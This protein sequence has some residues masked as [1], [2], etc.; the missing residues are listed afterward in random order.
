MEIKESHSRSQ[1]TIRL[2]AHKQCYIE[3]IMLTTK[4]IEPV[5]SFQKI[6]FQ[7]LNH[8]HSSTSWDAELS[9]ALL[10]WQ[11][12][13]HWD[14]W[15]RFGD[16]NSEGWRKRGTKCQQSWNCCANQTHPHWHLCQMPDPSHPI[17][18][19]GTVFACITV[20]TLLTLDWPQLHYMIIAWP[21]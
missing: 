1:M 2:K 9:V 10:R 11:S 20:S 15:E 17:G 21:F 8:Q 4:R 16:H 3:S 7:H 14:T 13:G 19:Q 18:K 12:W 5:M 6:C